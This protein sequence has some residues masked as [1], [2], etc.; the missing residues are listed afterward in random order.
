MSVKKWLV[1]S[2]VAGAVSGAVIWLNDETR[3]AK[4][5]KVMKDSYQK[6]SD[7]VSTSESKSDEQLGNPIP[8]SEDSKMVGEGA[9]YSV[10]RYNEEQQ[11]NHK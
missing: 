4:V 2:A 1:A 3:R 9:L 5:S 10:Q 6:V 7:K 8:I 11:L